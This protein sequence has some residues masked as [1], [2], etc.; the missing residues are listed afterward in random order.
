MLNEG[1]DDNDVGHG[2]RK[3]E[4]SRISAIISRK[5]S[6]YLGSILSSVHSIVCHCHINVFRALRLIW[7]TQHTFRGFDSSY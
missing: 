4:R 2:T 1:N 7:L 5:I 3:P 6:G